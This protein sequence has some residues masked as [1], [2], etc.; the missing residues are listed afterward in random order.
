MG[1]AYF[2][3]PTYMPGY[4]FRLSE[5]A[6]EMSRL[7]DMEMHVL[8]QRAVFDLAARNGCRPLEVQP[9]QY[10]GP[11]MVSN[12]FLFRKDGGPPPA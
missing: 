7:T 10:A 1:T 9:D 6:G 3:V 11:G 8:P 4:E 12:T 5:Y 2:Q